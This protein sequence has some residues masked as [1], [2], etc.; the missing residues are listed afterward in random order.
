[1]LPWSFARERLERAHNFW[2]CTASPAGRPHAAPIW[3]AWV[4]DRFYFEGSPATR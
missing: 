2:L 3:G 1:V 4:D